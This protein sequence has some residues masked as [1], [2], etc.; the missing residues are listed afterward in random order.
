[1][2]FQSDL[3]P[4]ERVEDGMLGQLLSGC[5]CRESVQTAYLDMSR[6]ES[7]ESDEACGEYCSTGRPAV[8]GFGVSEGILAAM[9]VPI[10]AFDD[11]YDMESALRRG[12]LFRQL[13]KPF[14][15]SGREEGRCDKQR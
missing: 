3:T 9:Y 10:Q 12:T 1:M 4:Q 15:G 5:S 14:Y 6:R 11:M 7:G 13:D 2:N 8:H